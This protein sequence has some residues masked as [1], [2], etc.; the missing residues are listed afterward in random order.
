[1]NWAKV[2]YPSLKPLAT[3]F[4]DM[5]KR[6]EFLNNWLTNGNPSSYWISGL[7][8]P[9][10]FLTGVLQTHARQYRIA[11]DQLA[12]AFTIM[13]EE[14]PEEIDEKPQDGV[15]V[16]GCFMDGARY[17]RDLRCIDEQYPAVLYD[18]MPVIHF[19]PVKDYNPAEM[20]YSCP[21][22]KTGARQGVLSTTGMSTNFVLYVEIPTN[23]EEGVF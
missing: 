12:F 23:Q 6:V 14:T 20:D 21:L 8:F 13:E 15:Y 4:T 16:Y 19:K 7:Y 3:W 9:Q 17:N 10:G 22:Y 1:M 5:V 11:I 2:A 18:Q